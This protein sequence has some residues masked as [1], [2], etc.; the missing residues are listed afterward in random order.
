[1]RISNA[2]IYQR[3]MQD[4]QQGQRSMVEAGRQVATGRR[5]ETI[6]ANPVSGAAVMRA[7]Q[8]IR[9]IEQNRRSIA[10]V[11][12]R[13][14]AQEAAVGQF[15]DL[16]ARAKE[17][18]VS[19]GGANANATTRAM[20]AQEVQSL[21]DQAV[22]L[23]NLRIG[24]EHIFGGAATGS[25][26]FDAAGTWL[27]S[28]SGRQAEISPGTVID[29]VHTGREL[30]V[31]TGVISSLVELRD[32]LLADDATAIQASI[33]SIDSAFDA[34]QVK[35]AETGARLARLDLASASLDSAE[36]AHKA[37]RSTHADISLDEAFT[38][39]SA[40]QQAME[41][42]MLASS[43]ILSTSLMEYLR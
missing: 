18:A 41:A 30:L 40:S 19:Q 42:A 14:D 11:R 43:K 9:Q 15:G 31:D 27:G 4:L 39:M 38:R 20:T 8:A 21:I 29:T 33:G 6:S 24:S 35:L 10:S 34:S 32:A 37:E 7:D 1:M 22:G 28:G 17:L 16:L 23:G 12:T 25:P 5:Y 26:P 2:N 3:L 13:L 36:D